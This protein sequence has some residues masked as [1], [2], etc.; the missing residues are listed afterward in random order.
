MRPESVAPIVAGRA[1]QARGLSESETET[2]IDRQEVGAEE[3]EGD[4]VNRRRS[5][6]LSTVGMRGES[7]S[8][9]ADGTPVRLLDLS[10]EGVQL[11]LP[12]RYRLS[13]ASSITIVIRSKRG[14][15]AVVGTVAWVSRGR[16]GVEFDWEETPAFA[17]TYIRGLLDDAAR[18]RPPKRR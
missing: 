17:K 6:R 16:C 13:T 15:V 12:I 1:Q 10:P 11:S 7:V 5:Q 2:E 9:L 4:G 18:P 8:R 14:E 3:N